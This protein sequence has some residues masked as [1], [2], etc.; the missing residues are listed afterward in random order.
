MPSRAATSRAATSS[1]VV[2]YKTPSVRPVSM[3]PKKSINSGYVIDNKMFAMNALSRYYVDNK[4]IYEINP[5]INES[6]MTDDDIRFLQSNINKSFT[7]RYTYA[8]NN[9]VVFSAKEDRIQ[10][11]DFYNF[12]RENEN[13]F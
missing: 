5:V 12:Y 10:K 13:D 11:M 7:L 3:K 8:G 4:P 1:A 6:Q 2:P 9:S